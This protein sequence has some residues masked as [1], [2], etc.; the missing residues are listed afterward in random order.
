MIYAKVQAKTQNI[1]QFQQSHADQQTSGLPA[2][3][4]KCGHLL[5]APPQYT[6]ELIPLD[7]AKTAQ[8]NLQ[9]NLQNSLQNNIQNNTSPA[10]NILLTYNKGESKDQKILHCRLGYVSYKRIKQLLDSNSIGLIKPKDKRRLSH[11][12]KLYKLCLAGKMK[13]LF[14]KKTNKQEGKRVQRLY[15]NL[16]GYYLAFI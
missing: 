4:P 2:K 7:Y 9:N 15:A 13:E 14:N 1:Y 5:G 10:N 8:N 6:L 3:T 11:G 16:S 12:E